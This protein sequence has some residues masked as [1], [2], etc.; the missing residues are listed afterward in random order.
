MAKLSVADANE[1]LRNPKLWPN[2]TSVWGGCSTGEYWLRC[3]PSQKPKAK[4]GHPVLA[5]AGSEFFTTEPD[6]MWAYFRGLSSVDV[7]VFEVCGTTQNFFD[8]R[9]RYLASGSSLLL[10]VPE[11]W[12]A[13]KIKVQR[14]GIKTRQSA[15][16]TLA[17]KAI[18]KSEPTFFPIR[19]LRAV[20]VFPDDQYKLWKDS[21]AP[22]GHEFFMRHSSFKTGNSP[23]TQKFLKRM[24]S[25]SHFL[26]QK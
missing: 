17:G 23:S 16:G 10:R 7:I 18:S 25:S 12:F 22:A 13:G 4:P 8:K 24:S 15:C 5:L 19:A 6:G 11:K 2:R 21:V 1:I 3:R 9:A 20:F 26:T 14:G